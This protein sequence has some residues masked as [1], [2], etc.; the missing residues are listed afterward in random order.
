M[1]APE[2]RYEQIREI[3]QR[4]MLRDYP[5]PERHGCGGPEELRELAEHSRPPQSAAWDHITHCSPCYRE[6]L[7]F[8]ATFLEQAKRKRNLVNQLFAGVAILLV[9]GGLLI[10]W[11]LHK[12]KNTMV[13]EYRHVDSPV[14]SFVLRPGLSRSAAKS[15]E[16]QM[17][18]MPAQPSVLRLLLRV[19]PDN[20]DLYDVVIQAVEGKDV[21]RFTGLQQQM[22]PQYGS[23][24]VLSIQSVTMK[25]GA[26]VLLLFDHSRAEL[27]DVYSMEVTR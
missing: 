16:K 12:G 19:E 3:L 9:V 13:A 25:P 21:L 23:V 4:A 1:D 15:Q 7:E 6:F 5:N 14:V 22:V 27:K 17:F 2:E 18:V 11:A 8:R 24:V 20:A 10:Y 26:Y